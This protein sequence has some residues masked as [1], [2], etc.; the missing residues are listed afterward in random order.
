MK[1]ILILFFL[2]IPTVIF[3]QFRIGV[4]GGVNLATFSGSEVV[5][6]GAAGVDPTMLIK[7]H[8]GAYLDYYITD[9]ISIQPGLFYSA[10]GP[11]YEG[12]TEIYDI[13]T[14]DFSMVDITYIKRLGYIDIPVLVRYHF[15]ESISVFIGPQFSFLLSAKVRN[16]ASQ[17]VLDELGLEKDEDV[18]D[19]Y[20]GFDLGLPFGVTYEFTNGLNVQLGYD[21]GL[22][23]IAKGYDF[24]GG[25]GGDRYYNVKNSVVKLSIGFVIRDEQ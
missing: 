4:R 17:Q 18:K 19:S 7:F 23:N 16:D 10:K 5:E 25:D 22:L 21:L 9:N 3:A 12:Q 11:K 8:L 15:N 2:L 20:R 13:N 1:K 14:G 24:N 6:W